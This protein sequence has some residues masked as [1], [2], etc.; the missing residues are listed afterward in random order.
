MRKTREPR[1]LLLAAFALGLVAAPPVAMAQ[2]AAPEA[3]AGASTD[4]PISEAPSASPEPE[5]EATA[6]DPLSDAFDRLRSDDEAVWRAAQS[7]IAKAWTRSG[8]DSMDLLL[9]RSRD[10]VEA[11]E[12]A[13]ALEHLGDLVNLAPR[14]AEAWNLRATVHFRQGSYGEALADLAEA[15]ALEPRHFSALAGLG[16][17]FMEIG[18][19]REALAAFRAAL[20]L[21]PNFDAPTEAI[22]RLTKSVDGVDA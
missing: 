15:V 4:A 9:R 7:E 20:E 22:E 12:W 18:Q 6:P 3:E 8:S 2:T 21:H 14:F 16:V 13:A 17:I 1:I 10:A 19:D 5:P 11:E